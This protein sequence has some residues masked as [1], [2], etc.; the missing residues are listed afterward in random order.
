M[1]T[2]NRFGFST[3]SASVPRL[4]GAVAYPVIESQ[5]DTT[6][7]S[8]YGN[9]SPTAFPAESTLIELAVE[10]NTDRTVLR[11]AEFRGLK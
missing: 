2:D 3:V 7:F 1:V 4:L 10:N 6:A 8:Y 5:Q 9:F 11:H